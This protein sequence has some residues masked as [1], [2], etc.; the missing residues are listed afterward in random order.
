MI[1]T[2]LKK[3]LEQ[4]KDRKA[5]DIFIEYGI[6]HI[7]P[8]NQVYI[9]LKIYSILLWIYEYMTNDTIISSKTKDF[10]QKGR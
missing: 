8:K 4:F 7:F 3:D 6:N 2:Y 5:R 1:S 9:F 10:I